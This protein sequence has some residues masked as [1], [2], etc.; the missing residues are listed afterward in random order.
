MI[1]FTTISEEDVYEYEQKDL[2]SSFVFW[3]VS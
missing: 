3:K 2:L 1:W